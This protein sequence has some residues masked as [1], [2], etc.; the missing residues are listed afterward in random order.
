MLMKQASSGMRRKSA[1]SVMLS[2]PHGIQGTKH[3][4]EWYNCIEE[5]SKKGICV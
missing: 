4:E 2:L 3:P 1:A 5:L